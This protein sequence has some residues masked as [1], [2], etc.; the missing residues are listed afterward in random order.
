MLSFVT[1]LYNKVYIF[2]NCGYILLG[3]LFLL[4]VKHRD[5][6]YQASIKEKPIL[7]KK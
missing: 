7:G 4:I 5:T 1:S 2:S 6:K 3:L